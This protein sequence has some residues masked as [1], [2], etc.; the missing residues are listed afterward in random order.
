MKMYGFRMFSFRQKENNHHSVFCLQH[1]YAVSLSVETRFTGMV[2]VPEYLSKQ[3]SFRYFFHR[4]QLTRDCREHFPFMSQG[5]LLNPTCYTHLTGVYTAHPCQTYIPIS[6]SNQNQ[7]NHLLLTVKESKH[8]TTLCV[9][10]LYILS[11]LPLP[12]TLKGAIVS[13][14]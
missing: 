3:S 7:H 4:L 11:S 9:K 13:Q 12:P 5:E 10:K 8:R 14:N 6:P 1:V 2:C